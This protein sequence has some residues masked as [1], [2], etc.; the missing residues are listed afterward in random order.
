MDINN[1]NNIFNHYSYDNNNGQMYLGQFQ[2]LTASLVGENTDASRELADLFFGPI[3]ARPRQSININDFI[4]I[5]RFFN[6]R[7]G[8]DNNIYIR[9]NVNEIFYRFSNNGQMNLGQFQQLTAILLGRDTNYY[10]R[11]ME[12]K[13]YVVGSSQT[14]DFNQFIEI[15]TNFNNQFYGE[16]DIFDRMNNIIGSFHQDHY[17]GYDGN[18][19]NEN[20]DN[21]NE[22]DGNNYNEND[23]DENHSDGDGN[24]FYDRNNINEFFYR[25]SDNNEQMNL[26][27]F[28]ELT[29]NLYGQNTINERELVGIFIVDRR[30]S[31]N[32]DEFIEIFTNFNNRLDRENDVF[33]R[34][35]NIIGII[36]ENNDEEM[37]IDNDEEMEIDNDGN[38]EI[39]IQEIM[40]QHFF[41]ITNG[42]ENMGL[43]FFTTF[44]NRFFEEDTPYYRE[45]VDSFFRYM[46]QDTTI[47]LEDFFH[48][49]DDFNTN[50]PREIIFQ[51]LSTV[52]ENQHDE[53]I[54]ETHE[55]MRGIFFLFDVNNDQLIDEEEFENFM[56]A[57][58]E[59]RNEVNRIGYNN[60]IQE[61]RNNGSLNYDRFFEIVIL[62]NQYLE[63]IGEYDLFTFLQGIVNPPNEDIVVTNIPHQRENNNEINLDDNVVGDHTY[64]TLSISFIKRANAR[65]EVADA[66]HIHRAI[67]LLNS[68][69]VGMNILYEYAIQNGNRELLDLIHR[70]H[71]PTVGERVPITPTLEETRYLSSRLTTQLNEYL[72]GAGIPAAQRD[73]YLKDTEFQGYDYPGMIDTIIRTIAH[74]EFLGYPIRFSDEVICS[75]YEVILLVSIFIENQPNNFQREWSKE[76]VRENIEA[77]DSTISTWNRNRQEHISCPL[78]I[79][80]RSFIA[81]S[82]TLKLIAIDNNPESNVEIVRIDKPRFLQT[83]LQAFLEQYPLENVEPLTQ[84]EERLRIEQFNNFLRTAI[85]ALDQNENNYDDWVTDIKIFLDN[86]LITEMI[87]NGGS[88]AKKKILKR[89]RNTKKLLK[90]KRN[91][92]KNIKK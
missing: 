68:P 47:S 22:D 8:E 58:N 36:R 59:D 27:Q 30:Q 33:D 44:V 88:N 87:V 40:T 54:P 84:D 55:T 26:R 82:N 25:Y 19:Y 20:D 6:Y 13:N 11:L 52:I 32:I 9:I 62:L 39:N 86:D 17:D 10:T 42:E 65:I 18:N 48:I 12:M 3:V 41:D 80:E 70:I 64:R 50:H 79:I 53:Y 73:E 74:A 90:R 92:K 23:G 43:G 37:E 2:E 69:D 34:I 38:E 72:S 63:G 16:Y 5:L 28:Y 45:L 29:A 77:Y 4:E 46:G 14:I 76:F 67:A 57:I 24:D 51:R 31:I 15:C 49:F 71:L 56:Q 83:Q 85:L 35:N 21:E 7:H 89:K 60:L 75:R 66:C 91:T 81:I 78:G 1:V 61:I